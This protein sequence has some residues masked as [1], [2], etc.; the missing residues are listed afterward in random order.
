MALAPA[1]HRSRS[2]RAALLC[3]LIAGA[4]ALPGS[5]RAEA[6][7]WTI[8]SCN[9]SAGEA[10]PLQL[11]P[12][13]VPPPDAG[14]FGV[15]LKTTL[16]GCTADAARLADWAASKNGT[17]DGASI[18]QAE[19][20]LSLTGYGNCGLGLLGQV[21][22]TDP[23]GMFDPVGTVKITW[24]DANGEKIK[25]AKPSSAFVHMVPFALNT[26]PNVSSIAEGTVTKGLGVGS[27]LRVTIP[28]TSPVSNDPLSTPWGQCAFSGAAVPG[29]PT[30][31]V[32][33]PL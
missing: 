15:K 12:A 26:F 28:T 18:A 13:A 8:V 5:A 3:G 30:F 32:G 25:S 2:V 10:P 24:L 1:H 23:A 14:K 4:L 29:F 17:T 21:G 16:D 22:G 31:P 7:Y 19:I 9:P 20:S 33:K 6:N 27:I 11:S